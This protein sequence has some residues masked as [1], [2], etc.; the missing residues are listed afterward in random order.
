MITFE[1]KA[2]GRETALRL[3]KEVKEKET[4]TDRALIYIRFDTQI[5]SDKKNRNLPYIR[6]YFQK[7]FG[8]DMTPREIRMACLKNGLTVENGKRTE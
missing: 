5:V 7:T 6:N 4:S 3:L 8:C 1:E 2:T